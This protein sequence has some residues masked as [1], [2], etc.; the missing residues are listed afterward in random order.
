MDLIQNTL[1]LLQ[2]ADFLRFIRLLNTAQKTKL[3]TIV[4]NKNKE[5]YD[6]LQSNVGK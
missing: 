3:L 4:Y 2:I 1:F 5:L 6:G